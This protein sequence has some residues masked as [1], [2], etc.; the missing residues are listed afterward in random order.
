M[1]IVVAICAS[2]PLCVLG[3]FLEGFISPPGLKRV[4][5]KPFDK[6]LSLRLTDKPDADSEKA[7]R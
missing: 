7:R 4:Q 3:A 2:A 5:G 1:L 6:A